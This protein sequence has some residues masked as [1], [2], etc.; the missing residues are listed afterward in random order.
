MRQV[1][2]TGGAGFIGSHCARAL[3]ER[4][5]RVR[6]LDALRPPVHA[7]GRRPDLPPEV[8]VQVG[9]VEDRA[10]LRQ[11]LDGVDAVLHLA[12]YQDY[13][14]DFSTFY[15]VNALGTALL[16]ELIV[17]E[18]LPVERVVVAATQAEYGEGRYRCPRD[19][20]V[21]PDPR[22]E[23]QLIAR[24]WEPR[25]PLCGGPIAFAP[26][27][28]AVVKPHSPY[29]MS[30]R[31]AEELA[32]TL[33]QR[34]GVPTATM[35]YSIVQGPGQSFRNAYS[36]ALRAFTVQ[37]LHGRAPL[38]YEDG[39]QT[40]DFV[41]I[42]DVVAANL[43]MLERPELTGPYNVGGD[44]S[45][46]VAEL[47]RLVAAAAGVGLEPEAPGLYRVGDTRHIR[48]D[49]GRLRALGWAPT[50]DQPAMVEAYVEWARAQP[51]LHDSSAEA[52]V[53][54]RR[55]GVLREAG[56]ERRTG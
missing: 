3:V 41:W 16:Y 17:A 30:K 26:T 37:A 5:A 46:T 22:P 56:S 6:V 18:R 34:Y 43:L 33:G 7:P 49:V 20:D 19:G 1:L 8:E 10:A 25:C 31:A 21:F 12:A 40:R 28:E 38:V 45:V 36:G 14:T 51:D 23:A 11:A 53:Q 35:R 24:D 48:S 55:L 27:D 15:L 2:V 32:L 29:A 42:G 44:R 50:G 13:L 54:M 52:L 47:A 4:G 39:Q 9:Q